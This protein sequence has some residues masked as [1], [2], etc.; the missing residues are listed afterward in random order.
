MSA[1]DR[2]SLISQKKIQFLDELGNTIPMLYA[3]KAI[4]SSNAIA[5]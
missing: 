4:N 3:V 5:V 2:V 1:K